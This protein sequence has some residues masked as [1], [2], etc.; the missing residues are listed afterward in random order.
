MIHVD[1]VVENDGLASIAVVQ[2]GRHSRPIVGRIIT[3]SGSVEAEMRAVLLAMRVADKARWERVDFYCDAN[4]V[5]RMLQGV[6][7]CRPE[8]L[9][10]YR[11]DCLE[12]LAK[13]DTWR[14]KWVKRTW[15]S[16]AHSMAGQLLRA[17]K[18]GRIHGAQGVR[19]D[20][21]GK[22]SESVSDWEIKEA[23]SE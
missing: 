23:V 21:N 6:A 11:D 4:G 13:H 22:F 19:P 15:N 18:H 5:V 1:A 20:E 14:I 12:L 7:N 17:Y 2:N 8:N 3:A 10:K 16:S 9:H